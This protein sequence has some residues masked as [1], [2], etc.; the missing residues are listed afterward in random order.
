MHEAVYD[1]FTAE[2]VRQIERVR[3]GAT[4]GYDTDTGSLSGADQLDAVQAHVADAV[5]KG[6]TVLAGG[7]ARPDLGPYFYAPTVLE[8]VTPEMD[9]YAEETFG[10]VLSVYRVGSAEEAI[11][12]ANDSRYGLYFGVATRDRARGLRVATRLEA[13][14]VTVNDSY[15]G[16]GAMDAP[17]GGMKQSGIGRRH[18]PEGIRKYTEAQTIVINRTP[19]QIGTRES[20]LAM[21]AR[22]ARVLTVLLW[23]WRRIPFLR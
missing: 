8:D 23:L 6:A 11:A 7:Y 5:E 22:L 18:G 19:W 1:A 13:G 15:M 14:T 21:N 17:M 3:L 9:V 20:P 2:V 16:W 4:P 12:Q 10:P